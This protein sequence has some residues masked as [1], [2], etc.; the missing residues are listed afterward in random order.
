MEITTIRLQL[1]GRTQP[2]N[3]GEGDGARDLKGL[4]AFSRA[5]GTSL[6]ARAAAQAWQTPHPESLKMQVAGQ[7]QRDAQ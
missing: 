1:H 7:S 3:D 4:H 6:A 2:R 5:R